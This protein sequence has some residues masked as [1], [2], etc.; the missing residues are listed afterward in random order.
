MQ[1]DQSGLP[2]TFLHA[3]ITLFSGE[4]GDNVNNNKTLSKKILNLDNWLY[5]YLIQI[6]IQV[7]TLFSIEEGANVNNNKTLPKTFT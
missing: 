2:P 1:I 4:E 6:L 7:I 5:T 3:L